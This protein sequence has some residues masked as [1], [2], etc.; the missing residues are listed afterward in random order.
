MGL[1][2]AG[3]VWLYLV[4]CGA[5]GTRDYD[6]QHVEPRWGDHEQ[7]LLLYLFS[8]CVVTGGTNVLTSETRRMVSGPSQASSVPRAERPIWLKRSTGASFF[9]WPGGTKSAWDW[10]DAE[11]RR[12]RA[13]RTIR[14]TLNTCLPHGDLLP[15]PAMA[16]SARREAQGE[17]G[18]RT[19]MDT[20]CPSYDLPPHPPPPLPC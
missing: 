1:Q 17:H 6:T 20:H 5:L 16:G 14:M 15:G 11:W 2:K 8:V 4:E 9:C 13:T 7:H 3:T 19:G 18:A 10:D 12:M